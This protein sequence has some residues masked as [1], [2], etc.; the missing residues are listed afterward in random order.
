MKIAEL[1][2]GPYLCK[3]QLWDAPVYGA[4][5]DRVEAGHEI[6]KEGTSKTDTKCVLFFDGTKKGLVL[7]RKNT[8]FLIRAFG[9]NKT[10]EW[11]GKRVTIYVDKGVKFG[12]EKVGGLRLAVGDDYSGSYGPPPRENGG[13]AP[14]QGGPAPSPDVVTSAPPMRQPGED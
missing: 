5:I 8:K 4:V 3:E 1:F 14:A 12:K 6:P 11:K 2:D 10:E 7:N 9:G 13:R